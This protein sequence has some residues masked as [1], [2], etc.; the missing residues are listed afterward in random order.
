MPNNRSQKKA[1]I[2]FE[3]DNLIINMQRYLRKKMNEELDAESKKNRAESLQT[4]S[5]SG[6]LCH[7]FA[8]G[9]LYAVMKD[10][11]SKEKNPQYVANFF[12]NLNKIAAWDK[13]TIDSDTELTFEKVIANT[14][15]LQSTRPYIST[16]LQSNIEV[17]TEGELQ[18]DRSYYDVF[19]S[20]DSFKNFL[21]SHVIA[22]RPIL[23][24]SSNHTVGIYREGNAYYCY[25]PNDKFGLRTFY[26]IND[27]AEFYFQQFQL[28]YLA[29][30]D[31]KQFESIYPSESPFDFQKKY[32]NLPVS[33]NILKTPEQPSC[34]LETYEVYIKQR[35]KADPQFVHRKGSDG[36]TM[37][38]QAVTDGNLEATKALLDLGAGIDAEMN[39]I[40]FTSDVG[41]P[42]MLK[43]LLSYPNYNPASKD[44][45]VNNTPDE[46][47]KSDINQFNIKGETALSI[48]VS[49]QDEKS[50][51]NF[52]ND[53]ADIFIKN[54]NGKSSLDIA[55]EKCLEPSK[56]KSDKEND[57]KMLKLLLNQSPSTQELRDTCLSFLLK[58]PKIMSEQNPK[59]AFVLMDKYSGSDLAICIIEFLKVS[60]SDEKKT[61]WTSIFKKQPKEND[62]IFEP[63]LQKKIVEVGQDPNQN[64]NSPEKLSDI[65]FDVMKECV[66]KKF[67]DDFQNRLNFTT[68]YLGHC[69][70]LEKENLDLLDV[71]F[72]F[73]Y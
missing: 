45:N 12:K 13:K 34:G 39:P 31:P 22:D 18:R 48:A 60:K 16:A 14:N 49:Q 66:G 9:F 72:K 69:V 8:M 25:D 59:A 65:V 33:L 54:K 3:Q 19:T 73:E 70:E 5:R 58:N 15:W 56:S 29:Q 50:I 46:S 27:V 10:K 44:P 52:L 23:L 64:V 61:S 17:A 32:F 68:K 41:S 28:V 62:E 20:F 37:L 26:H 24:E 7:G 36:A 30:F 42:E 11:K 51:R 71:D 63:M 43:L 1:E 2:T 67:S 6:G 40:S 35:I 57:M 55:L 47:S 4:I 53:G 21:I 38:Y